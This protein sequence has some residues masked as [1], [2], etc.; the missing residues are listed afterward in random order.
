M[1]DIFNLPPPDAK[2]QRSKKHVAAPADY[3]APK[4]A[5][6]IKSVTT[7]KP[8]QLVF[9]LALQSAGAAAVA[10]V[11]SRHGL[12]R[13]SDVAAGEPFDN[14]HFDFVMLC[15]APAAATPQR[16]SIF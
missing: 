14:L 2:A 9:D 3:A 4:R 15:I 16:Y 1:I 10:A 13:A 8:L 6:A 7:L 11:I 12:A 5:A